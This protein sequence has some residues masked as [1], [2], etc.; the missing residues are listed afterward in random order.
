MNYEQA[1]FN[2][3]EQQVRTWDVL[4]QRV[5]DVIGR[6]P[7]DRFVP[8]DYRRLAY[9]D[10][11]IPLGHGELMM[12]PRV[13]ARM[14]QALQPQPG[15]RVLE[16]GTGSGYV[17]ALLTAMGAHVT[18]VELVPEL[19][20]AARVTL[21]SEGIAGVTLVEGD[22][23]HGHERGAPWDAIAVTGSIPVFDP[24]LQRQLSVGGRLFVVV[25]EEPAMEAL[26]VTRV[27]ESEFGRE[28]LFETVL[29]PLRG[30]KAPPRFEL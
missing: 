21:A 19:Q 8:A 22:G 7:R 23:L 25:G 14:L 5:L 27:G 16:I 15:E 4:D 24:A 2:M 10:T 13:E 20:A 26:L 1:R 18:S 29:P 30:A 6:V 28:S 3:V 9:A 12:P 11:E 17:S